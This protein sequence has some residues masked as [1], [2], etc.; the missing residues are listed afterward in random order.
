MGAGV[1]DGELCHDVRWNLCTEKGL[2]GSGI[3]QQLHSFQSE[4]LQLLKTL[5]FEISD[6]VMVGDNP[7]SDIA[8][9]KA[10]GLATILVRRN[11]DDIIP[12]DADGMDMTPDLEVDSLQEVIELL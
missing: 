11:P 2:I 9:G 4:S 10:A 6:A 7:A 1:V 12:F 5:G 3:E 8:G